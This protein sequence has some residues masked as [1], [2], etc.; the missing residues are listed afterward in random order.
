M[1]FLSCIGQGSLE[2]PANNNVCVCVCVCCEVKKLR[3]IQSQNHMIRCIH[4][5]ILKLIVSMLCVASFR[6]EDMIAVGILDYFHC[7]YY[8]WTQFGQE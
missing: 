8:G 6:I 2:K 3:S 1:N 7:P 5:K 4:E